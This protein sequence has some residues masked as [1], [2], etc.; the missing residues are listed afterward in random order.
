MSTSPEGATTPIDI[1]ELMRAMEYFN[2]QSARLSA[3]YQKL[4]EEVASLN[5][6]LDAKNRY[7]TNILQSISNGVI[8]V[9]SQGIITLINRA[10]G[11]MTGLTPEQVVGTAISDLPEFHDLTRT[12]GNI[13]H[14]TL[15]DFSRT[16]TL[17]LR[18][19][20]KKVIEYSL[21]PLE[22]DAGGILF[23]RDMTRI[24]ELEQQAKRN[25]KLTA[26]GEM[27]ANI[28]HEIRNPLGSI[29]L[30]ASLLRRDLE[31]E[32][33]KQQLATN[34]V[35]GVRNLNTVISNLLLFTRNVSLSKELI[36]PQEL[37][38]EVL[39][40]CEHLKHRRHIN[41]T[42]TI[43]PGTPLYGDFDLLNQVL[44]NLLQNAMNAIEGDG[45]VAIRVYAEENH[46]LLEVSDDGC[47]MNQETLD[48]IFIPFYTSR[49]KGTG[50]GL[51]IVNRI[52][53]AHQ[54]VIRVESELGHGTRFTIKLPIPERASE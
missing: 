18:S 36:D 20:A 34:I 48:K 12:E 30:F 27:A 33:E 19:G 43:T 23:F 49:A 45:A 47:G 16:A 24:I 2:E 1:Q 26:M 41:L 54:G 46:T 31:Q 11:D 15:K 21:T 22:E 28:A 38:N 5:I 10:A 39:T 42:H 4:E 7:L 25:E 3:S 37:V 35:S 6:A 14:Q 32:P 52:I 44:L 17:H 8:S 50:L 53:E 40:F 51:S 13:A 29:E 9:D